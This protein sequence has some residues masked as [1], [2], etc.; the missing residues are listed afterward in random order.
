LYAVQPDDPA[1]FVAISCL[2]A[3]VALAACVL[4]AR[5]AMQVDPAG[6]LRAE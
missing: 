1:I 3:A 4:P 6:T 2:I 5:R